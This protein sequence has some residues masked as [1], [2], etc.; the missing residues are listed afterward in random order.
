MEF[1]ITLLSVALSSAF[2]ISLLRKLGVIEL[3]QVHGIKAK[4]DRLNDI[5][6][7][8]AS[9]DFCLSWWTNLIVCAIALAFVREAYV[10]AIPFLS[11]MITRHIL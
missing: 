1:L 7:K 8:L 11:T 2:I 4:S 3:L 5:V 6:S 10:F 9:C